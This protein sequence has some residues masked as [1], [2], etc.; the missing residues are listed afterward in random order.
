M[1]LSVFFALMVG[2]P[3]HPPLLALDLLPHPSHRPV[4]CPQPPPPLR[5]AECTQRL[6]LSTVSPAAI[7]CKHC[8][9]EAACLAAHALPPGRGMDLNPELL[10]AI[11]RLCVGLVVQCM[12]QC[13][14]HN[15]NQT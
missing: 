10:S 3:T 13:T 8:L 14:V 5:V 9:L 12:F 1:L 15:L 7:V 2:S 6:C 4:P 11:D